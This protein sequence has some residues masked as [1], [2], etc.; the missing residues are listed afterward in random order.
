MCCVGCVV[1]ACAVVCV[2]GVCVCLWCV[3]VFGVWCG[4]QKKPPCVNSKRPRVYR[5]HAHMCYHMRAWC[6][7]TEGR[8]ESTRGGFL[9]GHTGERGE[10]RE[11]EGGSPSV[12]TAQR[13]TTRCSVIHISFSL[14]S[15]LFSPLL[16]HTLLS[17]VLRQKKSQN[18]FRQGNHYGLFPEFGGLL[19]DPGCFYRN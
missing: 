12:L 13:V 15:S 10:R 11:R 6:R 9:D 16:S 4:T 14:L 7:Y 3:V 19:Q 8:F 1:C 2:C 5:H 18:Y 17:S